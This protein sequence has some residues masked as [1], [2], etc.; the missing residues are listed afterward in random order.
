M[1][2]V[3][4]P[5]VED[6]LTEKQMRTI[7]E[8]SL[9]A[10]AAQIVACDK[11]PA[12]TGLAGFLG[13]HF[14]VTIHVKVD[15]SVKKLRLFVKT[16]PALNRPK[17]DFINKHGYFRREMVALRLSEEM[18]GAEGP[19][20]WCSRVYLCNEGALVM[21]DLAPE[22]YK[23]FRSHETL[24]LKHSLVTAASIARFHAS[25]AN[26]ATRRGIE[27]KRA[28]NFLQECVDVAVEPTFCESPWLRAAA[29]LSVNF[30]QAFSKKFAQYPADLERLL[31]ERYLE[32]CAELKEHEDTLNVIIHKD[33]WI[34]NIM[35]KHSGDEPTNA[36]L[37]DFQCLRYG[38]PAFDLMIFL[39]LT[40]V[41]RFRER[42]ERTII[43]HYYDV[44]TES[45]DDATKGRLKE[46][47]Y[48]REAFLVW[49]ERSRMFAAFEA[50]GIFPFVL[51]DPASAQKTFDDPATYFKY[52]EV[53]RTEPVLDY[54]RLSRVYMER[55]LEVNEE[56]V[57]RY[58]L[59]QPH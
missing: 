52:C 51:M 49:C 9:G 6:I 53:D 4:C 20:P 19:N 45:L 47:N 5:S 56:F 59:N 55:Q 34:N 7:V 43:R 27:D 24:D 3:T 8:R 11:R 41:R 22:G 30:L 29:K 38:P 35:F 25:F 17:A 1:A 39:Y 14:R 13:D 31:V 26:Y 42:H 10:T 18:R 46:F 58:V 48:S 50:I 44:F 2:Y 23:T 28:Y 33:L 32:A 12:V 37:I 16:V 54:C 21:P 57:E 36:L 40:T 15:G